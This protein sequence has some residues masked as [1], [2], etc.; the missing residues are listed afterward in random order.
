VRR[1]VF[2]RGYWYQE[3]RPVAG[4]EDWEFWTRT[5]ALGPFR[6]AGLGQCVLAYRKWGFSMYSACDHDKLLTEIR[7][8]HERL[9]LWSLAVERSLRAQHAPSHRLLIS[10]GADGLGGD[11]LALL[12]EP[13]L[14]QF[15]RTDNIS[16]FLWVG[17]VAQEKVP[18]LQL[19]VGLVARNRR[20]PVYCFCQEGADTPYLVVYDR[21]AWLECQSPGQ[22]PRE[23]AAVCLLTGGRRFAWP[24][25]IGTEVRAGLPLDSRAEPWAMVG[26]RAA[27]RTPSLL[28]EGWERDPR[29]YHSLYYYLQRQPVVACPAA[30]EPPGRTL[31]V[32]ARALTGAEVESPLRHA[33][34]HPRLRARF[35]R[36]YLLTFEPHERV[37]HEHFEPLVDGIYALGHPLFPRDQRLQAALEVLQGA[38]ASDLLLCDC[39][40]GYDLIPRLRQSRMRIRL[41]ALLAGAGLVEREGEVWKCGELLAAYYAALFS[42]VVSQSQELTDHLTD[43]LYLPRGK[44]RTIRPGTFPDDLMGWLFPEEAGEVGSPFTVV[45]GTARAA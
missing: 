33:L 28:P 37:G 9:G 23:H 16:R 3:G 13:N 26:P 44:I 34:A 8:L 30:L 20:A 2:E 6:A 15:L 5:C 43:Y 12:P 38:Q 17:G 7:A 31:V 40:A 45:F 32:A 29:V 19:L 42:R 4:F 21:L 1:R 36:I 41:S 27:G 22:L 25:Q 39:P 24:M 11:D 35:D 10:A 14:E 18:S